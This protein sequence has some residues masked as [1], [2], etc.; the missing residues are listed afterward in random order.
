[1]AKIFITLYIFLVIIAL[2]KEIYIKNKQRKE[3]IALQKIKEQQK[4][5]EK[6]EELEEEFFTVGDKITKQGIIPEENQEDLEEEFFT[7]VDKITKQGITPSDI[8]SLIIR[9]ENEKLTAA[10]LFEAYTRA[11][12]NL[13]LE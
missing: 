8:D 2:I 4:A 11:L 7:D 9:L 10:V 12:C 13:K 3:Q 1:M 6:Q 5:E